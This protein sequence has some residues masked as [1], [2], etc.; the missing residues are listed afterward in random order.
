MKKFTP[1]LALTLKGKLQ[2]TMMKVLLHVV[3]FFIGRKWKYPLPLFEE[4]PRYYSFRDVAYFSYKYYH[5]QIRYPEINSG[6]DT[7]LKLQVFQRPPEK[8]QVTV[9]LGGDLM[10]YK[11]ITKEKCE[12]LWDEV[13]EY[14]FSSDIVFANLETPVALTKPSCKVPEVMLKDMLFNGDEDLFTIFNG[15]GEYN[16]YDVLSVANNHALDQGLDGLIETQQFLR[17][18]NI[19][20][21]GAAL[22]KEE[23]HDFPIIERNGISVAFIAFTF[24]LDKFDL[25]LGEE[26]RVNH[27]RLNIERPD[28]SLVIEQA[29]IARSRG[30]DIIVTSLHMGNAYQAYPSK[31][32]RDTMHRVCREAGVDVIVGTHPHN[33]QPVEWYDHDKADRKRSLIFYSLGDFVAYDIYSWSHLVLLPKLSI[34]KI[35]GRAMVTGFEILPVY[36]LATAGKDSV[37]TLSFKHLESIYTNRAQYSSRIERDLASTYD[38]YSNLLFTKTQRDQI[39][40]KP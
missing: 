19:A 6:I 14:F 2:V 17:Q 34:E 20:S 12:H 31:H 33:P 24:S 37:D 1:V 38:L 23:V 10:P 4:N 35:Q 32:I 28:I 5:T 18:Q 7:L 29:A 40:R 21:C 13:G 8:A 3:S 30:A 27:I 9:S 25:P 26:W 39:M 11:N 16:G 22:T 15:N 36:I